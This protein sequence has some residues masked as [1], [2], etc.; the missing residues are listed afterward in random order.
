MTSPEQ[1]LSEFIDA[2]N[3]GERPRVTDYVERV[4]PP[5]RDALAERI[6]DWLA[7][8]PTP[9]YSAAGREAIRAEPI[10]QRIVAATSS[11][12]GLLPVELA[13]MRERRSLSVREVARRVVERVGLGG[14]AVE[15]TATYLERTEAGEL[16]PARFSRRLLDALS[17]A[18][19]VSREALGE[20]AELRAL[21]PATAGTLYRATTTEVD[22]SVARDLDALTAAAAAPAP[23]ALDEVDRL[24][25][26]G[27]DA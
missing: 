12:S 8:A 23:A 25:L 14:G 22:A 4:E 1:V 21:R 3:A 2:W 20:A 15:Q 19:D 24:F 10:V 18:L 11:P 17:S 9:A 13:R 27:P 6:G 16:D 7:V 26:G 5:E